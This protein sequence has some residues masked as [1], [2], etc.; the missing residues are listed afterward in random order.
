MQFLAIN[1]GEDN[2]LIVPEHTHERLSKSNEKK[3]KGG[4]GLNI[5]R[6]PSCVQAMT[7]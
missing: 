5:I 2:L 1:A 6:A 3:I 7:Q 4:R